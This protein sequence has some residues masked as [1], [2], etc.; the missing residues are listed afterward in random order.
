MGIRF[1][2]L[3]PLLA[4]AILFLLGFMLLVWPRFLTTQLEQHLDGEQKRVEILG[5]ALIHP[6][7]NSD[8]AQV[9]SILSSVLEN[10]PH[11]RHVILKDVDGTRIYPLYETTLPADENLVELQHAI[12]F[13]NTPVATLLVTINLRPIHQQHDRFARESG[14]LIIVLLAV[15]IMVS[16]P[17]QEKLIT[18]PLKSLAT[19]ARQMAEGNFEAHLP[20]TGHDEVGQLI[21]SFRGMREEV[22]SYQDRLHA[23]AHHDALTGLPN[24]MM[25]LD[26]LEHAMAH[27]HRANKPLGLLFLDVDNFK[28]I[29]D[30][31]GHSAGD[32][33]IVSVAER[34]TAIMREGDTIARLGGDEFMMIVET[35]EHVDEAGAA[36][37]RIVNA[38][39]SPIQAGEHEIPVTV[40]IGITTYPQDAR[41]ISSLVQNADI[42]MYRAKAAGGGTY[43]FFSDDEIAHDQTGLEMRSKLFYALEKNQYFLEYQPRIDLS[44]GKPNCLEALIRWRPP[45]MDP[46]SPMEFIPLLEQTGLIVDV[47]E[48]VIRQS[49]R[50]VRAQ[51]DAGREVINVSAN[52]SARQFRDPH[53]LTKIENALSEYAVPAYHLELELT[54]G[55]VMENTQTALKVLDALHA[56]GVRLSIDDFGTGYSSLS[57]LKRFPVDFLKIDRSFIA[58]LPDDKDD[59]AIVKAI[60]ALARNLGVATVAEGV[61]TEQQARIL[62]LEGCDVVQGFL[63]SRPIGEVEVMDWITHYNREKNWALET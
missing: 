60:I 13:F 10:H 53:L 35:M 30:T 14:L 34:L 37:Q 49:C 25:F 59:A 17:F 1:K 51:L 48:W 23:L 57:Y 4:L 20:K 22:K 62:E 42:A 27:V 58:D 50:F 40:S 54:E 29:N 47:G 21:R 11:W 55:L 7:R 2:L 9:Y 24:R 39:Y 6:L 36:A 46:L 8:L 5:T 43:C 63:Y 15:A 18:T 38:F 41:G 31:L 32:V 12:T 44:T 26:R 61:E 28:A 56:M 3:I 52:L 45:G 33:L 19:A 16:I